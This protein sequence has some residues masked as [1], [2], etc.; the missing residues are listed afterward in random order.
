LTDRRFF[1]TDGIRGVAGEPPLTPG[2]VLRLGRAL[3]RRQPGTAVLGR[4]TRRSSPALRDALSAGLLAEGATVVDVGVLPTPAVA[5]EVIRRGATCGVVITASHNPFR[6]NGIKL[7]GP[8]GCKLDDAAEAG[9]ERELLALDPDAPGSPGAWSEQAEEARNAYLDRLAPAARWCDGLILAV[10]AANGAASSVAAEALG[11]TGASVQAIACTPD[12]RNINEGCGALHPERLADLV[13]AG[14][15]DLGVALDGD[16]DRCV[17]V[18]EDGQQ[19]DGDVLIAMLAEHRGLDQVVGTV[20]TNEG[21]VRHLAARGIAVHR[22]AVG[23]RNVLVMMQQ[24]GALLGGESSGHVI[25]L[26]RG[27]TGDGLA[28]ALAALQLRHERGERL[29]DLARRI[30]RYPSELRAVRVASKPPLDEVDALT[31]AMAEAEQRLA[32]Q[33]RVLVRYSGTEPVLRVFV[34]GADSDLVATLCDALADTARH[35]IG[36]EET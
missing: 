8:D 12:G 28:T 18:G 2:F 31:T 14:V 9:V 15:V 7:F 29:C 32:G 19:I 24:R 35:S 6:D 17:I 36:I 21:V 5:G 33:G 26:D 23:D 4:D 27:P 20:M 13:S 11:A 30:P 16:A 34:E 25:Q 22:A 10:D 1:G 3:A